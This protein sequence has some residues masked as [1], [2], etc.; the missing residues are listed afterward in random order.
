L[1]ADRCPAPKPSTPPNLEEKVA[2]WWVLDGQ[3]NGLVHCS[4]MLFRTAR[5]LRV[6][7]GGTNLEGQMNVDRDSLFVQ[8]FPVVCTG[9]PGS[10]PFGTRLKTF[11]D[12]LPY[13]GLGGGEIEVVGRCCGEVVSGVDFQTATGG[14][15]CSMPGGPVGLD[16]GG[17]AQLAAALGE[18][19]APRTTGG[20]VDIATGHFGH[21]QPAFV[22]QM[23]GVLRDNFPTALKKQP[24]RT[25]AEE[26]HRI[27]E[28]FMYHSAR[29]TVLAPQASTF[30][31]MRTTAPS[32]KTHETLLDEY[33]HDAVPKFER[34]AA[35]APT[36]ILHGKVLMSV[37]KDQTSAV[38]YVGSHNFGAT[39]WGHAGKQ[40]NNV[41]IGVVVKACG[42]EAVADLKARFPIQ[43]APDEAFRV[44]ADQRGYVMARGPTDGTTEGVL[45]MRWRQRCND[46]EQLAPF[47]GFLHRYWR[48]CSQCFAGGVPCS[49]DHSREGCE[50]MEAAAAAGTPFLCA[51]CNADTASGGAGVQFETSADEEDDETQGREET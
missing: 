49:Q 42:A 4:L 6:A 48:M 29:R 43:L 10:H 9:T 41:E 12:Y 36:P 31:V 23:T 20:R 22:S 2:G 24:T 46:P 1:I 34:E 47:R 45:Q 17:Y 39:A 40:P 5:F 50:A 21:L 13:P 8:D 35:D 26:W 30:A 33:F 15:V 19:D 3:R 11:L 44:P 37:S 38:M 18:I 16:K 7:V 51:N 32:K 28:C 25:D 14:L 27:G